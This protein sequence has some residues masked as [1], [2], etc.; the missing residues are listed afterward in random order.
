MNCFI[1][2][3]LQYLVQKKSIN[4]ATLASETGISALDLESF[5]SGAAIPDVVSAISLARFFKLP[6]DLFLMED[7]ETKE[8]FLSSFDFQMFVVDIDG[9]MTDGNIIY[10]EA[11]DEIKNFNA[12]DGL[13][14]IRLTEAGTKVGFLS[15]GFTNKIIE[16]RARVL[17]VQY[18]YIGTWNKLEVLEKWCG[19]LGINLKNV[20][21]IGD[22]L[23]DLAIIEKVGFSACPSD[24]SDLVKRKVNVVLSAIGGK[25]CVREFVDTYLNRYTKNPF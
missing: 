4:V 12:K 15:S 9:V 2:K 3:N 25:A 14:I 13:A 10:T 8:N 7:L 23:N 6:L 11:G 21:Y 20:A 18:V 17:G 22:D 19:E 5:I 24:A 1:N 16:K